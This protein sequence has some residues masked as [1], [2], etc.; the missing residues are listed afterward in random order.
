MKMNCRKCGCL[1]LETDERCPMCNAKQGNMERKERSIAGNTKRKSIIFIGILI[2]TVTF[3]IGF[4]LFYTIGSQSSSV[5]NLEVIE[6]RVAFVDLSKNDI[7]LLNQARNDHTATTFITENGIYFVG[8]TSVFPTGSWLVRT[9]DYFETIEEVG[10]LGSW[11]IDSIYVL[12]DGVYYTAFGD[13]YHHCLLN[14]ESTKIADEINNKVIV[15][16]LV[17]HQRGEH[18]DAE[19]LYI[20][21]LISGER[22]VLIDD[23]VRDFVIDPEN[24][25]IIFSVSGEVLD[26][27]DLFQADLTGENIIL[28]R[29]DSWDF[30]IGNNLI[31]FEYG[32]NYLVKN[33]ATGEMSTLVIDHRLQLRNSV[34]VGEYLVA[35]CRDRNLWVID[36]RSQYY[37]QLTDDVQGFTVLGNQIIYVLWENRD[38]IYITNLDG[39]SR[40][41]LSTSNWDD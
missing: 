36:T 20:F 31:A 2:V 30:T 23:E 26:P 32:F 14:G 9:T 6:N 10:L 7:F 35:M 27:T 37:H 15:D 8:E 19:P 38:D 17:F 3:T 21:D 34:F 39:N 4:V 16:H 5:D 41:I 18:W 25:R 22:R 29:H 40:N 11:F 12:E 13:L 24:D 33:L 28:L 1:I